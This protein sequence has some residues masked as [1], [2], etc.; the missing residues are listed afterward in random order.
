MGDLPPTHHRTIALW[1][2]FGILEGP[3][4]TPSA[5][6]TTDEAAPVMHATH[7]G[8]R[9]GDGSGKAKERRGGIVNI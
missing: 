7:S 6:T 5:G 4:A 1:T 9:A 3:E 8:G 2:P